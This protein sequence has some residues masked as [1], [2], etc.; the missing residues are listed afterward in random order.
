MTLGLLIKVFYLQAIIDLV[1][2]KYESPKCLNFSITYY[3]VIKNNILISFT[4][5]Q[6]KKCTMFTK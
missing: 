2:I 1:L 6:I 3:V 5:E 4:G